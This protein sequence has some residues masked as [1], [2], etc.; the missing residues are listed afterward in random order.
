MD[1]GVLQVMVLGPSR[2]GKD[3]RTAANLRARTETK[4]GDGS[5]VPI[6]EVPIAVL[7]LASYAE[8]NVKVELTG[9]KW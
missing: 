3:A 6:P 2:R 5:H 1:E 9:D 7:T 8:E 4:D